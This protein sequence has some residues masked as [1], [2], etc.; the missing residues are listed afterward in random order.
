[1]SRI[2]SI[3][4]LLVCAA[5]AS[6]HAGPAS[7]SHTL[8]ATTCS[9]GGGERSS[10]SYRTHDDVFGQLSVGVSASAN[11]TAYAG[12]VSSQVFDATA[13]S[14]ASVGDGLLGDANVSNDNS[15]LCA[16]WSASDPDSGL[17][18]GLVGFG[19]APGLD[20]VVPF[21]RVVGPDSSCFAGS[22]AFCQD[23]FATV[24]PRNG[25]SLFGVA[26]VSD[27]V[28][29]ID[30]VDT[31]NDGTGNGCDPDDDNDGILDGADSC[32]CDADNDADADGVCANDPL[33][34]LDVDNCD[35]VFNP[36]QLDTDG[37]GTG[38]ACEADCAFFVT[39]AI[40]VGDC[41]TIQSCIDFATPGCRIEIEPGL[42]PEALLIDKPIYLHGTGGAA[43]TM[44]K[45]LPG[46]S[47]VRVEPL[48]GEVTLE[49]LT[50]S[51]G[52]TGLDA[53][54]QVK[55]LDSVVSGVTIGVEASNQPIDATPQILL[56][57]VAIYGTS[58]GI[59]GLAGAI[60][61][62]GS[63]IRD[64]SSRGVDM[65]AG[66]L[67]VA[68]S[69]VSGN[70]FEGLRVGAAAFAELEFVTITANDVGVTNLAAPGSVTL[71]AGIV[72]GNA[73]DELVGLPC[74]DVSYSDTEA[75]CCAVNGNSCVDPL[76]ADAANLDLH[77]DKSSVCV[78]SSF[79]PANFTGRPGADYDGNRRLLDGNGDGIAEP[80]C[81]AFELVA[82]PASPGEVAGLSFSMPSSLS[83]DVEPGSDQYHVYRGDLATIGYDYAISCVG[84]TGSTSHADP[85]VP[86][87]GSGYVY[88]VSGNDLGGAEGTLGFGSAAERSN[89]NPCP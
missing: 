39:A 57:G 58:I 86:S 55:M 6:A 40:G 53:A 88:L 65:V 46:E 21:T 49:G 50:L 67:R 60:D 62:R 76:F 73:S 59:R 71:S 80:D 18:G 87:A 44:I 12:F 66:Q 25:A 14:P 75:L 8:H 23:Y 68:S 79:P 3:L 83:W 54:A 77:L 30:P 45:A 84:T 43:A 4:L 51:T 85:G 19:S 29:L 1:V 15:Q 33:C 56:D 82:V 13:P 35:A 78:D 72:W 36:G 69:I 22:F 61:V 32:P 16:N 17:F 9:E 70:T 20:D 7:E 89:F 64:N 47:V 41:T 31:D 11:F 10:E 34:A 52:A 63:W 42:Y 2:L 27:G 26:G 81:G 48:V 74:A 37:D 28:E 5:S 38:D 24:V